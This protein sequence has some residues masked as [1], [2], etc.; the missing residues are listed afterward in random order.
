[1]SR[2]LLILLDKTAF[3]LLF[4]LVVAW[5]RLGKQSSAPHPAHLPASP[6]L[7]VIRPG[8][9]GDGIMCVPLLRALRKAFPRSRITVAC[10]KK[11][12][13]ALQLLPYSNELIVVDEP[14][15]PFRLL[16]GSF[17]AVL[18]TEPF[19]LVTAVIAY[20][21]G[22]PVR[23]GF[24]TGPRRLLYTHLV[25]YAHDHLFEAANMVR[26][27]EAL[28]IRVP[29]E[30][31]V[32]LRF[33]PPSS[34]QVSA[35]GILAAHGADTNRDV[36]VAVAPGVLKPHHRWVMSEFAALIE[37]IRTGDEATK[38]LLIGSQRDLQ[39]S[40][41]VLSHLSSTHRIIDL[42]GKTDFGESLAILEACHILIACDGGVIHMAA[43]MGCGTVSLWGPG[44]MERFKPPGDRHI[45]VRKDYPCIPCVT[46]NRLGE[47]PGCPYDR[48]CYKAITASEVAAHC[49]RLMATIVRPSSGGVPREQ[50]DLRRNRARRAD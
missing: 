46:W 31:A 26:E 39:D 37:A 36:L 9:I 16:K 40:Q 15:G 20:L 35:R 13:P 48:K 24:D 43:A 12:K 4:W 42:I 32:D 18:D 45:G 22:A 41:E 21:T 8:G 44:V 30:E 1:M 27:L 5:V 49:S 19:R 50:E 23:I 25:T 10:V 11:S 6:S 7:L 34:A 17:D 14:G 38:I 2:D 47:F 3:R 28:G 33:D 29:E